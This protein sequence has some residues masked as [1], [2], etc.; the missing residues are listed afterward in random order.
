MISELMFN[1][2]DMP[3]ILQDEYKSVCTISQVSD[4]KLQSTI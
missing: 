2:S 1:C 4:M 3:F